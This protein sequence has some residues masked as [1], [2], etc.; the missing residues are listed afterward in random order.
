[1]RL[2][3]LKTLLE[4]GSPAPHE[5]SRVRELTSDMANYLQAY[6]ALV[7]LFQNIASVIV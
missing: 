6:P 1:M 3:E 7:T 4:I 2:D 5:K